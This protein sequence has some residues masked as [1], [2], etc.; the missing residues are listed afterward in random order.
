[1]RLEERA[2]AEDE[3]VGIRLYGA[4]IGLEPQSRERIGEARIGRRPRDH[5]MPLRVDI[6]TGKQLLKVGVEA[7]GERAGDVTL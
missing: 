2:I 7:L 5:K 6:D 4:E 1:M 3:V